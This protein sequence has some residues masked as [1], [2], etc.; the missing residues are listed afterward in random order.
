M[1]KLK[2]KTG[3]TVRVIAGDHKGT[4]GKVVRV[5]RE[6]NKA[7]VEGVNIIS[8]HVKPSASNP[9]GGIVKKEAPIQ[10][11]NLAIVDPKTNEVTRVAIVKNENGKNVRV[12]KK[13][14]QV[15]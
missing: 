15:L 10:I 6:K 13:S 9:Q 12:S 14:N 7:I 5:L 8:K 2:I 11:S 3:D 4:E 1:I